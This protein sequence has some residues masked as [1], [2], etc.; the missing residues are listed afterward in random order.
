MGE[1]EGLE[2]VVDDGEEM[3]VVA[4]VYLDEEVVWA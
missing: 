3:G 4:C 2:A 1:A